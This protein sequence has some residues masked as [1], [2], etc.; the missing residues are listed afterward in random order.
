MLLFVVYVLSIGCERLIGLKSFNGWG[1]E[2]LKN[3]MLKHVPMFQNYIIET[4]YV[5]CEHNTQRKVYII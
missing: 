1:S 4:D 2:W 5:A 3:N